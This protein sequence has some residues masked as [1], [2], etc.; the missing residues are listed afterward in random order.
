VLA[1]FF[2]YTWLY[3]KNTVPEIPNAIPADI[4]PKP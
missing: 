2:T 3:E 4:L 1:S